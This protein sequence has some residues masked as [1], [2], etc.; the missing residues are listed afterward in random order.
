M[1]C[2]IENNSQDPDIGPILVNFPPKPCLGDCKN[3]CDGDEPEAKAVDEPV[4]KVLDNPMDN[5]VDLREAKAV[6]KTV[7]KPV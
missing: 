4:A 5:I 2:L 3:H 6:D 1:N 7:D